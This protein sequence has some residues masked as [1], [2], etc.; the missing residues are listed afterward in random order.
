MR[1]PARL[2]SCATA[3]G[4]LFAIAAAGACAA[5][6]GCPTFPVPDAKLTWIAPEISYNGLPMEIRKFDA[7]LDPQAILAFYRAQ[8]RGTAQQPGS[9]EY[10]LGD[11]QVIAALREQCFYTVQVRGAAKGGST[12]LLGVSRIPDGS[13]LRKAGSGFPMLTGTQVLNDIGH[14]DPGKNARTL[15]L[16]NE[17]SP[18]SNADFYV[19]NMTGEGWVLIQNSPVPIGNRNAY[20]LTFRRGFDETTMS[21]ARTGESTSVLVNVVAR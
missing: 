1:A 20:V 5:G 3:H 11:W 6:V 21:I 9:V 4:V 15:L 13:Q 2:L 8:W 17:F 14:R 10:P 18:D 12:G 19:R 16:K 7:N